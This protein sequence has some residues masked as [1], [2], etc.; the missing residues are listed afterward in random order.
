M[1]PSR[2]ITGEI[3][4]VAGIAGS[5]QK[6]LLEAIAGLQP[7]KSGSHRIHATARATSRN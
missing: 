6:E 4:G 3:L 2:P 7:L 1:P 5:G